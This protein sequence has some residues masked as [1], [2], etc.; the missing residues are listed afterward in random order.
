MNTGKAR[1]LLGFLSLVFFCVLTTRGDDRPFDYDSHLGIA[2]DRLG[3]VCLTIDN[4]RLSVKQRITLVI[5][6]R[7]QSIAQAEVLRAAPDLCQNTGSDRAGAHYYVL[8]MVSGSIAANGPTIAVLNPARSLMVKG[9]VVM[10]DLEGNGHSEYFRQC[11]S[12]EGVH[13]TVWTGR[14]LR[15]KRRWHRYFYLGYDVQSDCAPA[16]TAATMH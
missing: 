6:S 2:L 15:G 9:G 14:P 13:L 5:P 10:G 4:G 16:E 1:L 8:R 3:L 12:S 11:T 7:P